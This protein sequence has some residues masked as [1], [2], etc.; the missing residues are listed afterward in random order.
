MNILIVDNDRV[1]LKFVEKFLIKEGHNV[2]TAQNGLSALDSLK[3]FSPDIF[4]VDYVM[5]N[6]D[7]KAFCEILKN[8]PKYKSSYVVLVSAIAAEEWA[9]L[10]NM[11]ANACIAKSSLNKMKE[12]VLTLLDNLKTSAEYCALGNVIGLEDVYPRT[13]TK[14]LLASKK[15]FQLLL[16]NM[17]EGILQLNASDR[18]VYANPAA[19]KL[20]KQTTKSILGSSFLDI[21]PSNQKIVIKDLL[22]G[23][24]QHPGL[25]S[26]EKLIIIN[27]QFLKFNVVPLQ[28]EERNTLVIIND[29]SAHKIVEKQLRETNEFFTSIP[30]SSYSISIISTDLDQNILFWNKGAEDLFGYTAEEV[31]GKQ[32]IDILYADS[33][34]KEFAQGLRQL[35][36]RDKR[37]ISCEITERTKD[38]QKL[39]MK[40]HLSPRIGENGELVGILGIGEDTTSRKEAE[41]SLRIS[42]KKYRNVVENLNVG[43]IVVKERKLVF[44]NTAIAKF[45]GTPVDTLLQS[46]DP[47]DF[48]HPEDRDAVFDRHMK[49]L[50]G[51]E[52]PD[53]HSFRVS[54]KNGNT[55]WIEVTSVLIDWYGSSATLSFYT[56]I[57]EQIASKLAIEKIEARYRQVFN[58]APAGICEVDYRKGRLVNVNDTICKYTGYSRNE[59]LSKKALD[60]LS[61]ESQTIY[62]NRLENFLQE[63]DVPEVVECTALKKDGSSFKFKFYESYIY[64]D[65]NVVGATIVAQDI[66]EQKVAEAA[67]RENQEKYRTAMEANPDPVVVYDIEGKITYFNPAFTRVFGWSLEERL[68]RKLDDFVPEKAWPET[69]TMIAKVL[70]GEMFSSIETCRYDKNGEIILVAISGAVYKDQNGHPIG[71][72]IN[73]RDISDQKRTEAQLQ[74]AQKMEA[75]GTLAGGIA[76][77]FNNLLMGIQGRTSLLIMDNESNDSHVEHLRGIENYVKSATELTK[78]LLA[79]ARGGKYEILPTDLNEL[80]DKSSEMFGRTRKEITIHRKRQKE[81]WT[82]EVDQSQIEQVMVNLYVNAWQSMPE[83]GELYIET[84]NVIID[85]DFVKP[86]RIEFGKYVKIS[87]IDTGIG[88]DKATQEKIFDPFFT[89]KE[90]GKGTGLGLA[91]VYGIVKNH[92]G[93][94]NVYSEKGEGTVFNIY[95]PVSEKIISRKLE[96]DKDIK[97]GNETVL[98]VDDEE[99]II[100]VGKEFIKKIGY[101]VLIAKTGKAAIELYEANR[102]E[103]DI[104]ILDMIMPEMGGG[105]T[106]DKL[107]EIDFEVKVLL[108]SGYSANGQATKILER[109][110]NGFIQKPFNMSDLSKKIREVLDKE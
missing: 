50:S 8:D 106:Y 35:L 63:E 60:L 49:R 108:S 67:L 81:I 15:H 61:D 21:L 76:H 74:Q 82:V 92:N 99:M 19:Q 30:N 57:T 75:I 85:S 59:L 47:F 94:I 52:F 10:K 44:A 32:K 6:I 31:V 26:S 79:F 55:R 27:N 83:G 69:K 66:T 34:E 46:F 84:E 68:G 38:G 12:H 29:I 93:F 89:T 53:K 4:F 87:V 16:E 110:C 39:F 102:D 54:D 101:K 17:S 42:E 43:M 104:V 88:M 3:S 33:Q 95:L 18:I 107:K 7:G 73:L 48:I 77:D 11:G 90:I 25:I 23:R 70:D 13:I 72:V 105:D 37:E 36:Q 24:N 96:F 9:D 86:Y 41:E 5:P 97:K 58:I 64:E 100:D 45:F 109:G 2:L 51:D 71:S 103:I 80:I 40:L 1:F 78:Q 56:D 14:E 28:T 98:L 22:E 20:F 91:S 65:K 62:L